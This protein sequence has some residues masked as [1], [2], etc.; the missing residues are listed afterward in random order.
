MP[1]PG[2]AGVLG[3][4]EPSQPLSFLVTDENGE[5]HGIALPHLSYLQ[6]NNAN[7][8]DPI[9]PAAENGDIHIVVLTDVGI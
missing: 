5:L 7:P 1:Q 6:D 2:T 8:P 9:A 3:L 4:H